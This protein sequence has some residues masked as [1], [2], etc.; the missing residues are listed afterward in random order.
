MRRH[1]AVYMLVVGFVLEVSPKVLAGEDATFTTIDFPGASLTSAQGITPSGDIVGSYT[2]ADVSHGF[3]LRG[4]EFN[5]I[6]FPG[7]SYTAALGINRGGD[8]VGLY[9]IGDGGHG[10]LLSGGGNF[11]T[12]NFPGASLTSAVGINPRGDIVG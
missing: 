7:A 3:L 5:S 9:F 6:D 1:Q 11:T 2:S 8:I 4:G 10:F 12:I